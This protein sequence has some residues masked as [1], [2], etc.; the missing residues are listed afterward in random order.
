MKKFSLCLIA[1]SFLFIMACSTNKKGSTALAHQSDKPILTLEE[2]LSIRPNLM[3]KDGQIRLKQNNHTVTDHIN[4]PLFTVN[5]SLPM[6]EIPEGQDIREVKMVHY[7]PLTVN[8]E[9]LF[10]VN[11][12]VLE[13]GFEEAKKIVN[14]ADIVSIKVLDTPQKVAQYGNDGLNGVIR[15]RLKSSQGRKE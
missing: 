15:I 12:M 14:P 13:E 3:L 2:H 7:E 11:G 4:K 6:R 1:L 10:I 8:G 9:P 5:G